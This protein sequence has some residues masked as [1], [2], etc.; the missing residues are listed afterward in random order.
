MLRALLFFVVFSLL[1]TLH[2]SSA[3][4]D[5]LISPIRIVF[6]E[7]TRSQTVTLIN[8]SSETRT[9]RVE[10]FDTQMGNDG[11]YV[12]LNEMENKP[13]NFI[14]A[15]DLI[16]Y[17]PRQVTLAP[18]ESQ[19]IRLAVRKPEGLKEG[20]Y[21]THMLMK[22]LANKPATE[23][24]SDTIGI[25]LYTN[26]SISIPV[27]V[28]H[29][30]LDAQADIS[31]IKR[32]MN[33]EKMD[34][35]HITINRTGTASTYG[36]VMIYD[37]AD[38]NKHNAIGYLNNFAIFPEATERT[39][40]VWFEKPVQSGQQLLIVYEGREDTEGRTYTEELFTVP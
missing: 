15:Q 1:F 38:R 16:R 27:I 3:R 39:A 32:G 28:R 26:I 22:Q 21:R 9:Y 4:A 18:G 31:S 6:E 10:F 8:Q 17:S 30:A 7:R 36:S 34:G 35:L 37:P 5:L 19:Q 40:F 29:G 14:S 12:R 13:A 2:L 11:Q 33:D 25:K 20:E 24:P 23:E